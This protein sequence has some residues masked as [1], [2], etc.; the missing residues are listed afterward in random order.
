VD[1][2]KESSHHHKLEAAMASTKIWCHLWRSTPVRKAQNP[3][4]AADGFAT[5]EQQKRS[6][7]GD[8]IEPVSSLA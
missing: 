8:D 1:S 7:A 6:T 5:A 4:V 3:T 2:R